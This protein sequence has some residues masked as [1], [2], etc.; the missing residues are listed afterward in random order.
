MTLPKNGRGMRGGQKYRGM[1]ALFSAGIR[2]KG[3]PLESTD[4]QTD[5]F[6][7]LPSGESIAK[8]VK[9]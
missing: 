4:G 6:P 8:L 3:P 9:S 2:R 5:S 7:L 1:R